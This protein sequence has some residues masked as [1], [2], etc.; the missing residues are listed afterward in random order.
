LPPAFADQIPVTGACAERTS[1]FEPSHMPSI[2]VLDMY[3]VA[4]KKINKEKYLNNY[5]SIWKLKSTSK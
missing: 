3:P 1:P 5:L 4:E 2:R